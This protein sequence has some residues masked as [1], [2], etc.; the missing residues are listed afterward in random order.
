MC[1]SLEGKGHKVDDVCR[2]RQQHK[3]RYRIRKYMRDFPGGSVVKTL[4]FDC[5]G[6]WFD[7]WLGNEDPICCKVWP[8]DKNETKTNKKEST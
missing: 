3:Q 6:L 8:K 5:R 7:S 2:E 1:L 4:H